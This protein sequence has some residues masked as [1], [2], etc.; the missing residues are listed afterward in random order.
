MK[1][2]IKREYVQGEARKHILVVL[3]FGMEIL[4]CH[5]P[6]ALFAS[7]KALGLGNLSS[8]VFMT[9]KYIPT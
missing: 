2:N 8:S 4:P 7:Q 3:D 5:Y 6:Q 9:S 1:L